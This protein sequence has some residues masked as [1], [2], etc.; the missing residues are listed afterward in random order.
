MARRVT[1][2]FPR[3]FKEAGERRVFLPA[4]IQSLTRYADVFLEE[5]YGSRSGF[6][7]DDFRQGSHRVFKA[8]RLEVF[9]KDYVIVLRSPNEDEFCLMRPGTCL[10]S[11]LHFPTRPRR[12]Q[13]LRELRI[14]AISM[15]SIVD[16]SNLRLVENMRAVAWNGLEAAFDVLERNCPDLVREG[17]PYNTLILGTGMVGK[18][19]VE[20]ATKFGNFERNERHI[21]HKGP[22]IVALSVGR[23]IT[24]YPDRMEK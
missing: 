14:N 15:D 8:D 19:A 24:E 16:D 13:T 3:M 1:I 10:V 18:H 2:G 9:K 7:F 22:G 17:L 4:F 21:T 11:M 6:T 23:N 20:A 12:V 5:G